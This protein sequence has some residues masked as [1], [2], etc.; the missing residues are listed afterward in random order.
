MSGIISSILFYLASLGKAFNSSAM[1]IVAFGAFVI[2]V[3]GFTLG[4]SRILVSMLSVYVA[5]FIE[6][7]LPYFNFIKNTVGSTQ[8]YLVHIGLFLIFFVAVFYIMNRSILKN[9]VT[10]KDSS[11]ISIILLSVVNAGLLVSVLASYL[12]KI[13]T[14]ILPASVANF[15]GTKTALFYWAVISL[16]AIFFLKGK[17]ESSTSSSLK[18][19]KYSRYR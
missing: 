1:L 3:I 13:G 15:V 2:F 9:R 10:L 19:S 18:S 14:P 17:R 12:P 16:I 7:N 5:Y 4:R 6:A 8:S 11:I